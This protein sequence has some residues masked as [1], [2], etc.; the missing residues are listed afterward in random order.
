[1]LTTDF[2]EVLKVRPDLETADIYD[3]IDLIG[4]NETMLEAVNKYY[5][6]NQ[7]TGDCAA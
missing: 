5:P 6:L 1:M 2:T 7:G 3:I 4:P